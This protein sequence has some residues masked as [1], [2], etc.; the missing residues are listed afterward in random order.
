MIRSVVLAFEK[1]PTWVK[2]ALLVLGSSL[3]LGLF[4]NIA[5][6]LPF[7]PI[8][9]A[10]QPSIVLLLGVLLGSKRALMAVAAFLGQVAIG[11][12]VCAGGVGG[13]AKF[14]GPTAGYLIGYLVAAYVVGRIMEMRAQRTFSSA[15]LAMGVGNVILFILGAAWLST[16]VGLSKA[17]ALGVVPFVLGDLLKLVLSTNLLR[18]TGY[19]KRS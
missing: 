13:I 12:P 8:P 17:I 16:F 6:P 14:A 11:L 19:L 15:F 18:W 2:N 4:A 5:I 10:T 3:I 7:T 9:I 1:T